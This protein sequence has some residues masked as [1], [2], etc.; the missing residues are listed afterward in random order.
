MDFDNNKYLIYF[1][2]KKSIL[3]FVCF[4]VKYFQENIFQF[5]S[6]CFTVKYLIKSKIFSVNQINLSKFM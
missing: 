2:S 5:Y 1:F 6:I 4:N 3:R